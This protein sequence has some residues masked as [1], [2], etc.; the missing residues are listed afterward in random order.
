MS[1][2]LQRSFLIQLGLEN[3]PSWVVAVNGY[4][5]WFHLLLAKKWRFCTA[6][7]PV[8]RTAGQLTYYMVAY[9]SLIL[10][11]SKGMSYLAIY[12]MVCA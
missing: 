4:W 11:G 5:R 9:S 2:L 8:T 3:I 1:F 6:V 10:A 7:G 12:L